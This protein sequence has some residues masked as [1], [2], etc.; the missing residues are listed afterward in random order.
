MKTLKWGLIGCGDISQNRVA[1][2]LRDLN[3]C[4][5]VAVNRKNYDLAEPFA[6]EFGARK[7]YKNWQEL[8][9][10]DDIKAVYIATPVYLHAEQT[11]A[12]AN[13]GKHI[14]C[15][16][17][18]AMNEKECDEMISAAKA[19][20]VKLGIAYYRHFY[21]V[22]NRIKDI[23][24]TGGIGTVIMMQANSAGQYN[25]LPGEP[26]FWLLEKGKS[27]GGP[28]MDFGCHRIELM[29]NVLGP[30]S[31]VGSIINRLHFEREV[32]D[33]A[34]AL[35]EFENGAHGVLTAMHSMFEDKDTLE[36]YGTDGSLYVD[37][38]N[39]GQLRIVTKDGE[40]LEILPPHP[41]LH[42]P[43]IDDFA[44]AVLEDRQPGVTGVDGKKTS[45]VLDKIYGN[46][47][48]S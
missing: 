43:H 39:K 1:P 44:Q 10:D 41:N 20:N 4:E 28:M 12:A 19:N 18:M 34:T 48:L 16:K 32:E 29:Q 24:Q 23:I 3:N 33:T 14:L 5:F 47:R 40:Q 37:N 25:P 21:P 36:I 7:W 13:A 15:E 8:I 45:I 31:S 2:A 22:V 46:S 9:D 27:G 42:L 17:P 30:I 11:I 38:L 6:L 26:R 35:F